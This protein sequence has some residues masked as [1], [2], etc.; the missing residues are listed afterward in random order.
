MADSPEPE[1]LGQEGALQ[2]ERLELRADGASDSRGS[3]S[4]NSI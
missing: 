3:Q 2:E 4:Q 1:A